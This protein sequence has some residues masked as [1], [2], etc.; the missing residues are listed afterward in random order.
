M[1]YSKVE[2]NAKRKDSENILKE[3]FHTDGYLYIAECDNSYVNTLVDKLGHGILRDAKRRKET[4]IGIDGGMTVD[5]DYPS[6][7]L[8]SESSF[9]PAQPE[10]VGFYCTENKREDGKTI[11]C[12]GREVWRGIEL[13]L[14]RLLLTT[15][16]KYKLAIDVEVKARTRKGIRDWFIDKPGVLDSKIDYQANK[17]LIEYMASP[18]YFDGFSQQVA[19]ANHLLIDLYTEPQILDRYIEGKNPDETENIRGILKNL[20]HE[21]AKSVKWNDGDILVLKNKVIMHGRTYCENQSGR[22]ISVIQRKGLRG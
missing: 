6:V 19:L 1:K 12:D 20:C 11:I 4:G 8:H 14:K 5:S 15:R 2:Y 3:K 7:E 21:K 17:L 22:V 13:E 16:I 9:S 10:L 18:V